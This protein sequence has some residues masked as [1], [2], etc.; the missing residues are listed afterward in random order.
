MKN[1]SKRLP[2][3]G[4][5]SPSSMS[6]LPVTSLSQRLIACGSLVALDQLDQSPFW[7]PFGPFFF[8]LSKD[9]QKGVP[10]PSGCTQ[11]VSQKRC[12]SVER[13]VESQGEKEED[14]INHGLLKARREQGA[15]ASVED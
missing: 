14:I 2:L 12:C 9:P 7:A 3:P 8:P 1:Q 11:V 10:G 4:L 15:L 5:P 6:L 13:H